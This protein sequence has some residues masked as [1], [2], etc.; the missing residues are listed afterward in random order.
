MAIFIGGDGTLPTRNPGAYYC[1]ACKSTDPSVRN[2]IEVAQEG[3]YSAFGTCSHESHNPNPGLAPVAESIQTVAAAN[4]LGQGNMSQQRYGI[5][6]YIEIDAAHRVPMHESKCRNL[7]GHRYRI[8][9]RVEAAQLGD[10]AQDG[11]V[12]DFGFV[13]KLMKDFIDENCDHGVILSCTDQKMLE[14]AFTGTL[15]HKLSIE[16]KVADAVRSTRKCWRGTTAFGKT[17]II[18]YVPTAENLAR[19]WFEMLKD[20]IVSLSQSRANLASITVRETP[21]SEATFPIRF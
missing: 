15:W 12:L 14:L 8:T 1:P 2:K 19:F 7:H 11:M 3:G 6:T 10:G 21:T 9:A 4:G 16:D 13:K 20:R 17:F 5:E 18:P